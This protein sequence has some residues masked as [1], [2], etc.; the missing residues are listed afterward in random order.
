MLL[1]TAFGL[2]VF[3]ID[4]VVYETVSQ[5]FIS[6]LRFCLMWSNREYLIRPEVTPCG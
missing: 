3:A 4:C 5:M 1:L 6:V 2:V